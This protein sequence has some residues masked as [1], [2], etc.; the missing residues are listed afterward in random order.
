MSRP[1]PLSRD[2]RPKWSLRYHHPMMAG[3]ETQVSQLLES[4]NRGD[5]QALETL[6]PLVV[7]DLRSIA[8]RYFEHEDPDHTLQPTALVNELYLRLMDQRS[9]QWHGPPTAGA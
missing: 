8:R 5:P 3:H 7:D 2:Q 4:W 6:M 9:V 1:S